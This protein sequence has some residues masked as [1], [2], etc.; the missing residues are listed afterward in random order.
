MDKCLVCQCKLKENEVGI[1]NSCSNKE[2]RIREG[3][4]R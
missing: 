2:D 4:S 3:E 1:C